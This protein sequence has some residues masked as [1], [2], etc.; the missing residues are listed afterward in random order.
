MTPADRPG[1]RLHDRRHDRPATGRSCTEVE[2]PRQR[3]VVIPLLIPPG[4]PRPHRSVLTGRP[5]RRDLQGQH[6][7]LRRGRSA[8]S[9]NQRLP[10]PGGHRE[11]RPAQGCYRSSRLT[12]TVS[13][14]EAMTENSTMNRQPSPPPSGRTSRFPKRM[15]HGLPPTRT[16]NHRAGR[17]VWTGRQTQRLEAYPTSTHRACLP[18]LIIRLI[19]QTIRPGPIWI[20][21]DRR[22][23][24]HEQAR[25]V[26]SRPDRHRAPG[27]GSGGWG[28]NPSRHVFGSTGAMSWGS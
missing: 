14:T 19:I 7:G 4:A 1:R 28:S 12:S 18:C 25:S 2:R 22:G 27:Y 17:V 24:Q 13:T 21:P 8:A 26:W 11:R 16:A 3:F 15:P 20:R 10:G 5:T 6:S 9:C 23:L